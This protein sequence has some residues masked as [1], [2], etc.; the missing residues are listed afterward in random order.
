M[1]YIFF[2]SHGY[3][4]PIAKKLIDEGNDVTVA[5]VN[6][7][8]F[9]EANL[10]DADKETKRRRLSLYDGILEKMPAEKVIKAMEKI[11]DKDEYFVFFDLNSLWKYSEMVIKMGFEKGIFPTFEDWKLE[12]DRN[13]AKGI[14][15]KHYKD[16]EIAEVEEF[17]SVEDAE[18][19]LKEAEHCF[20]LK[21]NSDDC[22]TVVPHTDD[23]EFANKLIID[24][25][26][27]GRAEYEAA[28]FILEKK[29]PNAMEFTPEMFWCNRR[30][31][32]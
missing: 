31:R 21:G 14:V 1:K 24:Q 8:E 22:S 32:R 20:V 18:E 10:S 7:L 27:D 15:E 11:E 23:V 9:L 19:F 30:S 5:M 28:G 4:L 17:K 25:L 13:M 16:L 2:T 26:Q 3:G 12:E 6:D 29:I